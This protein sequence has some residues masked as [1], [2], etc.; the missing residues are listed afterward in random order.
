MINVHVIIIPTIIMLKYYK[1][2]LVNKN[3]FEDTIR[4]KPSEIKA[5]KPQNP[6][7]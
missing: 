1:L 6:K 4:P 3:N 5:P 2:R 7:I